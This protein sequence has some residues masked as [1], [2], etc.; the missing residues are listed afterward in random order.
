MT[1]CRI[2]KELWTN[3]GFPPADIIPPWFSMRKYHLFDEQWAHWWSQFR[4]AVSPIDII[5]INISH[6]VKFSTYNL[7]YSMI[8]V[9][10][11]VITLKNI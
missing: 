3:Q 10:V 7:K 2:D 1:A 11:I 9:P 8:P 4:D 6:Y 5:I